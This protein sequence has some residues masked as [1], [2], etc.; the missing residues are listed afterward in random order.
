ML[1]EGGEEVERV[2]WLR[3]LGWGGRLRGGRASEAE[4]FVRGGGRGAIA[5]GAQFGGAGARPFV[6][7]VGGE[8]SGAKGRRYFMCCGAVDGESSWNRACRR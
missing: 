1:E 3:W 5:V 7:R 2:G 6:R 4:A 8:I